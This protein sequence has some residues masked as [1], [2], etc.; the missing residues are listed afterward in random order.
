MNLESPL[1]VYAFYRQGNL[2]YELCLRRQCKGQ[3]TETPA[4]VDFQHTLTPEEQICKQDGVEGKCP[5]K[6]D[7]KVE[8]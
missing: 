3:L 2:F 4:S 6:S 5:N 1:Q 8:L 7:Q